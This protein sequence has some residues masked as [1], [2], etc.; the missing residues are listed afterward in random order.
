M[1]PG[2][3]PPPPPFL[4]VAGGSVAVRDTREAKTRTAPKVA[5]GENLAPGLARELF[6][7]RNSFEKGR[8]C[9]ALRGI[10]PE[11]TWRFRRRRVLTVPRKQTPSP[12][13]PL[14]VVQSSVSP[15]GSPFDAAG[16]KAYK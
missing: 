8:G 5:T 6:M 16:A 2:P 1:P 12:A 4:S 13:G 7:R 3:C 9:A 15:E 11:A 14:R 10:P